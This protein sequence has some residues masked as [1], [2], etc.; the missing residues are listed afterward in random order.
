[1]S[2]EANRYLRKSANRLLI[3]YCCKH[4]R[5]NNLLS[6]SNLFQIAI[7]K[8]CERSELIFRQ[9]RRHWASRTKFA[10]GRCLKV[11]I[12]YLY[13]QV[14][15][16]N[17]TWFCYQTSRENLPNF[18]RIAYQIS[19]KGFAERCDIPNFTSDF[20][21]LYQTSRGCKAIHTK[22]HAKIGGDIPNFTNHYIKIANLFF[23]DSCKIAT[24]LLLIQ[25]KYDLT[26]E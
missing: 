3:I 22:L 8:I 5:N 21:P 14:C 24:L 18:T 13:I 1:M 11:S 10:E 26:E 12:V 20:A 17:F 23:R 9:C 16:P 19:R 2:S 4:L 15:Q 6:A 7:L 25:K